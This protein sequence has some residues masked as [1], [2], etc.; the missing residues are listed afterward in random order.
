MDIFRKIFCLLDQS[1]RKKI[2]FLLIITLLT[3]ILDVIG[4]SSIMP[5]M[6]VLVN[7]SVIQTNAILTRLSFYLGYP[8]QQEFL[9]ILG[10][11]TFIFL[12]LSL[13]FRAFLSYLQIQFVLSCECS[14]SQKLINL[15][16]KQPYI[17]FLGRHSGELAKSVLSEVNSVVNGLMMPIVVIV[18]QSFSIAAILLMLLLVNVKLTILMGLIALAISILLYKCTKNYL[19]KIGVAHS[20]ANEQRFIIINEVFGAAK[21]VKFGGHESSYAKNFSDPAQAYARHQASSQL[22]SQL[23]RYVLEGIAFGGMLLVLLALMQKD[24]ISTALPT[25]SLYVFAGYRIMPGVQQIYGCLS[26]IHFHMPKLD[27]LLQEMRDLDIGSQ[28]KIDSRKIEFEKNIQVKNAWFTY[29]NAPSPTLKG[30]NFTISAGSSVALVGSTGSG[31]TTIADLILGLIEPSKGSLMVD[32]QIINAENSQTWR[33]LIGYV[34]QQIFIS[35]QS[36][37]SN[38]AFGVPSCNID[39]KKLEWAAKVAHLHDFIVGQLPNGYLSE[40]GERGVRLSGGQRQRIG[41]ARA[42]Y[43][44]P[45]VLVLD[46]ATSALDNITESSVLK[47]INMLGKEKVTTIMITHRLS[48][49]HE[50]DQIYFIENGEI[51]DVG[52]YEELVRKNIKFRVMSNTLK[53]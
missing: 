25:F 4:A 38:I 2:F 1:G 15:Y 21:E 17:W 46:E 22:T 29:P 30:I 27:S 16:L 41:I 20:E 7:P 5:F 48:S 44:S 51:I 31:K 40:I 14:I 47:S 35:N 32:G 34:P 50:C 28:S 37:A 8:S 23:P 49:I 42:M 43:K 36:I 12:I 19:S 52:C 26:Q 53:T 13:S 9:W 45:R 11:T 6:A 24:G 39:Q 10:A 33:K 18:A 3:G